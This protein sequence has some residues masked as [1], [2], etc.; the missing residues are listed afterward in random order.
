MLRNIS[1]SLTALLLEGGSSEVRPLRAASPWR[2]GVGTTSTVGDF[3]DS[4]AESDFGYGADVI[5]H[6]APAFGR[7]RGLRRRPLLLRALR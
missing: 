3:A 6:L 2:C 5:F 7:L 4:S 1:F